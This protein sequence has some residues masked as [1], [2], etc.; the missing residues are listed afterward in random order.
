[1]YACVNDDVP[2]RTRG[3]VRWGRASTVITGRERDTTSER[4]GQHTARCTSGDCR[5]P[6]GLA[7]CWPL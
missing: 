1:M 3:S 4:N 2:P 6:H 5:V 7:E